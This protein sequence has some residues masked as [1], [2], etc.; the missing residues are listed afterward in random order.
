M[1]GR[2]VILSS[3]GGINLLRTKGSAKPENLRDLLNGYVDQDG[4]ATSRPGSGPVAANYNN[5]ARGLTAYKGE[6]FVFSHVEMYEWEPYDYYNSPRVKTIT[7]PNRDDPDSPLRKIWFVGEYMGLLY[8]VAEYMNG[9]VEHFWMET[10]SEWK[11]NTIYMLGQLV[12]Q[13]GSGGTYV[14]R[15]GRVGDPYPA[16][17]PD[18]ARTLGER[19]EPTTQNGWYYEVTEANGDTPRSGSVEPVW[20]TEQGAVVYEDVDG[21]A[22]GGGASQPP[23]DTSLPP[24]LGDRYD[25]PNSGGGGGES[26]APT[27]MQ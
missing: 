19:V 11:P 7:I 22:T 9:S 12:R 10:V 4:I 13:V 25:N 18:V 6:L 8:V 1:A 21:E 24:G 2:P 5:I 27:F 3:V 15:A 20:P 14:Y 17:A 16:W 26:S 23:P